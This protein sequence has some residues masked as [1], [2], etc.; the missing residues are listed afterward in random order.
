MTGG[1]DPSM[2]LLETSS[3]QNLLNR[4]S[5]LTQLEQ[6]NGAKVSLVAA[7]ERPRVRAQAAA[8]QQQQRAKTLAGDDGG[9]G[10]PDP[11]EGE[12]LQ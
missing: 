2:Q 10:Q 9:Q 1:M 6:Q 7:A 5:I 4:A 3:P 8:A 11:E 12:L